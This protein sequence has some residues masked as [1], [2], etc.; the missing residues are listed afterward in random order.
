MFSMLATNKSCGNIKHYQP[1]KIMSQVSVLIIEYLVSVSLNYGRCNMCYIFGF[2]Y[3]FS[4]NRYR[5]K[6]YAYVVKG[7]IISKE[8]FH[9][10]TRN[11]LIKGVDR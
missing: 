8:F 2:N 7:L 5:E 11:F 9:F 6:C 3:C 4:N 10:E 1:G